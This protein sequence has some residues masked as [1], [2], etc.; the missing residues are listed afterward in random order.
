MGIEMGGTETIQIV[1]ARMSALANLPVDNLSQFRIVHP[2]TRQG[3]GD[4]G[5]GCIGVHV[6]L[7]ER[8]DVFFPSLGLRI[9]LQSGDA[10]IWANAK[11]VHNRTHEDLRTHHFHLGEPLGLEASLHGELFRPAFRQQD[12][13]FTPDAMFSR[14]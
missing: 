5:L 8:D 1:E 11:T 12:R 7:N 4:R 6:C 10:L 9:V 3:L 2:G 14:P 13:Y